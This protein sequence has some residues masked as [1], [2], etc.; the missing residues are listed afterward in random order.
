MQI[1]YN[2]DRVSIGYMNPCASSW[3]LFRKYSKLLVHKVLFEWCLLYY[4]IAHDD[5][6]NCVIILSHINFRKQNENRKQQ[7]CVHCC[8]KYMIFLHDS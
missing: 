6:L 1:R 8:S 3:F 4:H 5:Q 7:V 2:T